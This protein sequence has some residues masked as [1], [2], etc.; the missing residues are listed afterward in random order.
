MLIEGDF[1][2]WFESPGYPTT[3]RFVALWE[4][5]GFPLETYVKSNILDFDF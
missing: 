2:V 4:Q 3:K 1:N 5:C